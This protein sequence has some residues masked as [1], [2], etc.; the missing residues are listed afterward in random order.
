MHRITAAEIANYN[1]D[2]Y[3]RRQEMIERMKNEQPRLG[4]RLTFLHYIYDEKMPMKDAIEKIIS[5]FP[6]ISVDDVI[7]WYDEEEKRKGKGKERSN[8]DEGR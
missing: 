7:R 4:P 2:R 1:A 8:S 3:L 5:E 6:S